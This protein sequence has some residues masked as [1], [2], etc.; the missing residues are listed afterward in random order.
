MVAYLLQNKAQS[1]P[2]NFLETPLHLAAEHN[3]AE[4]ATLLLDH[5]R[6]CVN[7]LK[8]ADQRLTALHIAAEHGYEEMVAVLLKYGA[9]VSQR[10]IKNMT[11]VHLA[12]RQPNEAV[13][14]QLLEKGSDV[15]Q[16]MVNNSDNEGR[17]PLLCC[18]GSKGHG[19]VQC[20]A[21]LVEHG[22]LVDKQ[23]KDGFTP[24]H[25]A[26]IGI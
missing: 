7:S 25:I 5:N 22:A 19:V 1:V 3:L 14:R 18:T 6:G 4:C 10:N 23:N 12:A 16:E 21:L 17:T 20:M 24:L 26:A 9:D 8:G 13:L 11:A 2:R 15:D